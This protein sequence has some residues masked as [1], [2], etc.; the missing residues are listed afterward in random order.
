M[1]KSQEQILN[2]LLKSKSHPGI[3]LEALKFFKKMD[4]T[5]KKAKRKFC[6]AQIILTTISKTN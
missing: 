4:E 2:E 3:H 6:D 5:L 1:L